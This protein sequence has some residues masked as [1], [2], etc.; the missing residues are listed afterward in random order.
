MNREQFLAIS[1]MV[2]ILSLALSSST[3]TGTKWHP[4]QKDIDYLKSVLSPEDFENATK[5]LKGLG[6]KFN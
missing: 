1:A 6:F 4:L 5:L 3:L 2:A